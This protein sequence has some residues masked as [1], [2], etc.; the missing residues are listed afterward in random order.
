MSDNIALYDYQS[1]WAPE[2][3]KST[4]GGITGYTL[5]NY[6]LAHTEDPPPEEP[7]YGG[8]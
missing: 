7:I 3:I 5:G 6:K 4:R 1:G 2:T 8:G